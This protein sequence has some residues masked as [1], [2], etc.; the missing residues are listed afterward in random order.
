MLYSKKLSKRFWAE[1]IGTSTY[2][3]NR[4]LFRPGTFITPYELVYNNKSKVDYIH[5]FGCVC[6][7]LNDSEYLTKFNAKSDKG[8]FIGY[9]KN[10][11]AFRVYNLRTN[12]IQES[13]N[14]KFD[15][16]LDVTGR[17]DRTELGELH[18]K[19]DDENM[20]EVVSEDIGTNV[21]SDVTTSKSTNVSTSPQPHVT[22]PTST[23]SES[24]FVNP[25]SNEKRDPPARIR[26][27]HPTTQIIDALDQRVTRG[28]R[29]DYKKMVGLVCL[30]STFSEVRHNVFMSLIEP[31][32]H[33][34]DLK[35][36]HWTLAMQEELGQFSR[37]DVLDLVAKS[38][39]KNVIGTKWIFKNK[40]DEEG[41]IVRNKARLVA[42]GY[43]QVE[44]L[45]FGETFA[46][47]ARL[48]SIRLMLAVACYL[49]T[50]LYQIDIKAA[51]L[52]GVI[53]E[54]VYVEQ[55][56]GYADPY[57][58]N[59]VFKLKKGIVWIKTST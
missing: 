20:D 7:I 45:D 46:P 31:K 29:R 51:F 38:F 13:V 1:A 18:D 47:V 36:Y 8:I 59:D 57:R 54:E 21:D 44:G 16:H 4:V 12:A 2:I 55:P 39:D 43:T 37:S 11:H 50:K 35:D 41:N 25:F 9:A 32:N 48:E 23:S 3:S 10:N 56:K 34:E 5:V 27:D 53:D 52:N 26:N 19:N 6:Y 28:A 40:T 24:E 30:T 15:D 22:T 49:K 33:I 42:H 14:V 58:P 17:D